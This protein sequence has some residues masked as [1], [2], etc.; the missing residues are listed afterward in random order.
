MRTP[1]PPKLVTR[2]PNARFYRVTETATLQAPGEPGDP[3]EAFNLSEAKRIATR[4]QLKRRATQAPPP[5]PTVLSLECLQ[6]DTHDEPRVVATKG[7]QG[8][9]TNVDPDD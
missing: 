1:K 9:W 7:A 2:N 4:A 5:P 3:F 8:H 6:D